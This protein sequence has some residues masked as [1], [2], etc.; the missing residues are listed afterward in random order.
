MTTLPPAA[1]VATAGVELYLERELADRNA[2]GPEV[3][4]VIALGG[5]SLWFAIAGAG[6]WAGVLMKQDGF[7]SS[8]EASP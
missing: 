7:G 1:I 3:V 5:A 2:L 8:S 6:Y 4:F